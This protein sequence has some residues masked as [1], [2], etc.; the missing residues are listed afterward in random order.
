MPYLYIF[1]GGEIMRRG[2][3]GAPEKCLLRSIGHIT[4]LVQFYAVFAPFYW[5][6]MFRKTRGKPICKTRPRPPLID[7]DQRLPP[8]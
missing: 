7:T 2:V 3:V 1:A 5:Y 6:W 4:L 8:S